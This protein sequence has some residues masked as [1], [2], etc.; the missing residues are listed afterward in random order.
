VNTLVLATHNPGKI[1]EIREILGDLPMQL[2]TLNDFPELSH[3]EEDGA[4]FEENA[5]KKA[6]STFA[7]TRLP[8][9]AD[10]SGLE[11]YALKMKPGVLSARYA[12]IGAT[13]DQ[14]VRKLLAE[15]EKLGP[16]D[17]RAQFRCVTAF[18]TEGLERL[19]EGICKGT[20]VPQPRGINGFGY[21]P[22]FQPDG[23]DRTFAELAPEDKNRISHRGRALRQIRPILLDSFR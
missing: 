22:I 12:G 15:L 2:L 17:R 4:T 10:D 11:V 6:R 1:R 21:D 5:L 23:F 14:R 13:D 9:L 20:I 7:A 18:E 16:G 3:I 8:T 19:S